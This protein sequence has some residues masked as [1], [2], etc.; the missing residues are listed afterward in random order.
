MDWDYIG[1]M[2]SDDKVKNKRIFKEKYVNKEYR[3]AMELFS[4][5]FD[6]II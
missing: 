2:M 3:L 1:R 4:K 6:E 5:Y